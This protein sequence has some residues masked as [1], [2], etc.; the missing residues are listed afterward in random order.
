MADVNTPVG[1]IELTPTEW[2]DYFFPQYD[3]LFPRHRIAPEHRHESIVELPSVLPVDSLE[4]VV[5]PRR[6]SAPLDPDLP[7]SICSGEHNNTILRFLDS[8]TAITLAHL[9]NT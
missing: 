8:T 7:I 9:N 2:E 5:R 6:S 4:M 3:R 1:L